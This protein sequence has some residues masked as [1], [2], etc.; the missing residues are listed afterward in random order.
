MM[1]DYV[2]EKDVPIT[3]HSRRNSWPFDKM[4]V[5]DSFAVAD[6]GR[7]TPAASAFG[8]RHGMKFSVLKQKEGGYR[9]W[10]TE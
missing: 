4:V 10:R 3:Q 6:R 2:I 1:T 5:G 9:C 7:V 8:I